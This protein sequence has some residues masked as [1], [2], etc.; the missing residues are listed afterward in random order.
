[1]RN[2][3]NRLFNP[4]VAGQLS[5]LIVGLFFGMGMMSFYIGA[6]SNTGSLADWLGA[7]GTLAAVIISL[8]Y[9]VDAK[10]VSFDY[11]VDIKISKLDSKFFK[12]PAELVID[13]YGFN[14]GK[15]S[16]AI[17]QIE[18]ILEDRNRENIIINLPKNN[19]AE[20]KPESYVKWQGSEK[21]NSPK[22]YGYSINEN[23]AIKVILT[24]F[25][26][27]EYNAR[28]RPSVEI[29]PAW[30]IQEVEPEGGNKKFYS[31]AFDGNVLTLNDVDNSYVVDKILEHNKL[32]RGETHLTDWLKLDK[33]D[34]ILLLETHKKEFRNK[35]E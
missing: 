25:R 6:M 23:K 34:A 9:S 4:S 15:S 31:I 13:L 11:S 3:F 7:F 24:S 28:V 8:Y 10:R 21:I 14:M 29:K 18:L 33:A 17:R 27:K 35:V 26:G 32:K 20:I 2:F 5:F 22:L 30:R 1:M 12:F 19:I 16:D